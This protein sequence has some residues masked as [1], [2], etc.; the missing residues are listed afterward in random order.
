[1]VLLRYCPRRYDKKEIVEALVHAFAMPGAALDCVS[2]PVEQPRPRLHAVKPSAVV[3]CLA[4]E[5]CGLRWCKVDRVQATLRIDTPI[6]AG[7]CM[8]GEVGLSG[9]VRPVSRVEQRIAEAEKLGF[10]HLILPSYSLKSVNPHKYKIEL[11]PVRKVEEALRA[12]F[13]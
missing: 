6:E 11:H 2:I 5:R 3:R 1:L 4:S 7:W 13:G 10:S 8:C 9:E 12:L